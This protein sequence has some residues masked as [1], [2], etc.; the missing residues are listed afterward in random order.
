MHYLRRQVSVVAQDNVLFSTTI[1]EN[2]TFGLPRE[3]RNY[4]RGVFLHFASARS[5][6][7]VCLTLTVTE[8]GFGSG[9][10]LAAFTFLLCFGASL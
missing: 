8:T 4:S 10:L 1:R 7:S 5:Y 3:E 2:I 6:F 9:S